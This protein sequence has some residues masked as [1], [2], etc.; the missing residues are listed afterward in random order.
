MEPTEIV[1]V[2]TTDDDEPRVTVQAE[3]LRSAAVTVAALPIVHVPEIEAAAPA[4]R[5]Q[6]VEAV[7]VPPVTV[8]LEVELRRASAAQVKVDEEITSG[9][10][11]VESCVAAPR[12]TVQPDVQARAPTIADTAPWVVNVA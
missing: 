3:I 8:R 10:T 1:L 6:P 12:L 7:H 9:P 5:V 4:D 11:V 2:A